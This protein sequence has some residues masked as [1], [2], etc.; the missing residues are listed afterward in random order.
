M[1]RVM[2]SAYR[3]STFVLPFTEDK[4]ERAYIKP[5]TD[6]EINRIRMKA[7]LEGGADDNLTAQY[8]TRYFLEEA[9]T[10]WAGFYD[11]KGVEIPFTREAIKEICECDPEFAA[12]MVLRVRNIARVGELEER[13]N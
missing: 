12:V 11:A 4:T 6:T 2:T 7:A 13:K 8:F 10:D 1:P 3:N 5:M 9:V